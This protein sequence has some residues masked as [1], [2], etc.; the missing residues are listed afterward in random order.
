MSNNKQNGVVQTD[1]RGDIW[2]VEDHGVH[3]K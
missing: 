3:Q 2:H 1:D